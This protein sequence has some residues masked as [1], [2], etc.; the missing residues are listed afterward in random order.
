[1]VAHLYGDDSEP[2]EPNPTGL[3][4]VP[5]RSGPAGYAARMF[6]TPLG[7]RTAVGFT[8]QARLAATLGPDQAWIPLSEPALRALA[9]PLGVAAI[10]VDPQLAAPGVTPVPLLTRWP[11][12]N[13]RDAGALSAQAA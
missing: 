10:T 1:M 2:S 3:L 5:V 8:T 4:L 12:Q 7:G 11:A 6:R 13:T 9:E